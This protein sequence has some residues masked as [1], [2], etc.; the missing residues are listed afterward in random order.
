MAEETNTTIKVCTNIKRIEKQKNIK[1]N[2]GTLQAEK[3]LSVRAKPFITN[4]DIKNNRIEIVGY[5]NYNILYIDQN[6]GYKSMEYKTDFSESVDIPSSNFAGVIATATLLEVSPQTSSDGNLD[7]DGV[8][9]ITIQAILNQ[10]VERLN[11][12]D[13]DDDFCYISQNQKVHCVMQDSSKDFSVGNRIDMGKNFAG[14]V[15][16]EST[17]IGVDYY[18]GNGTITVCGQITTNIL[19][20][21]NDENNAILN[22]VVAYEFKQEIECENITENMNILANM[23]LFDDKITVEISEGSEEILVTYPIKCD[24]I[25][26]DDEDIEVIEDAYCLDKEVNIVSSTVNCLQILPINKFQEQIHTSL[27]LEQDYQSLEKIIGYDAGNIVITKSVAEKDCISFEGICYSNIIY[28]SFDQNQENRVEQSI[29][30]EIPFSYKLDF[31]GI[32]NGDE[33]ILQANLS[34]FD[35]RIKRAQ[36]LDIFAQIKVQACAIKSAPIDI[37]SKVDLGQE[38]KVDNAGIS[39]YMAEQGL[40]EWE[41]AKKLSITTDQLCSQNPD[42]IFPLE[43]IQKVVVYRGIKNS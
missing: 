22:K 32:D 5:V 6:S 37:T 9:N 25:V 11:L 40:T 14:V 29:V 41:L 19:Y 38:K 15:N 12:G 34:D 13:Y 30:A 18:C 36:E 20:G 31:Q 7:I 26:F 35:A 2:L 28:L 4:K 17:L 23:L 1:A 27:V 33:V 43:S 21:T 42:L 8:I 39:I 16:I 3:I 24:Y 10:E